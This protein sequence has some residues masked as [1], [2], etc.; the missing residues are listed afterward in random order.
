MM[1]WREKLSALLIYLDGLPLPKWLGPA[2]TLAALLLLIAVMV[3]SARARGL[4]Y[5]LA[6]RGDGSGHTQSNIAAWEDQLAPISLHGEGHAFIDRLLPRHP[7]AFLL[8]VGIFALGCWILGLVLT[9]EPLAFLKSREWQVQPVYMA[10]HLVTLRLFASAFTRTFLTGAAHL[11][12]A[13]VDVQHRMRLV[14]GPVGT[15]V[16]V[17]VAVPFCL[18]DYRFAYTANRIASDS[19]GLWADRLLFV[20]WCVEWFLLAFI[21]VMVVGY[22][23]ITR[24][25]VG[26]H[27]FRS[28]IEV[29]LHDKQYRPFLQMSANGATI[30]LGF[31]IINLLY[32]LYSGAEISDYTGAAITLI[33]V[34]VGFLPPLLLLRGKVKR[35]V[36][37]EMARLRLRLAGVLTRQGQ[38]ASGDAP[39]STPRELEERLDEALVMLRIS[40]LERLYGE[41]GHTEALDILVKLLV[42]ATTMAWYG[43]KYA[44]G[45]A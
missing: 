41:L 35:A 40:Y 34:V 15:M 31:W 10:A 39:P 25:A 21:W 2:A 44:K 5:Q 28:P 9:N 23:L 20:V 37:E 6:Q 12:I 32:S 8:V 16:A 11:D 43:Y 27:R 26:W 42:P 1:D 36:N 38:A 33:L 29:V 13:A 14:L 30:M 45:L 4:R 19:L 18:Y 17:A 3:L 22:M 7:P 24:W